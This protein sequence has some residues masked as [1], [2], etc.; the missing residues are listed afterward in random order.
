VAAAPMAPP[1][2]Q[3]AGQWPGQG[4]GQGHVQWVLGNDSGNTNANANGNGGPPAFAGAP[5][6]SA[7]NTRVGAAGPRSDTV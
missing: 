3:Q 4:Q 1:R 5:N 6:A 2:P 7:F